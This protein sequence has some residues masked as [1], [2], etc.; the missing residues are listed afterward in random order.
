M[1]NRF[2]FQLTTSQGGRPFNLLSLFVD[3]C[4]STH[5]LARR[6]TEILHLMALI[7]HYFNSRPRKEVD[8]YPRKACTPHQEFQ[9]TTSQGGRLLVLT[10]HT[11]VLHF[12]SRPRK[13]VDG[14]WLVS[15][16]WLLHLFQLT[17]SQGGRPYGEGYTPDGMVISTH[18]LARRSTHR[19]D[20]NRRC[21]NNF[22]SRPR[23]EVDV[24][25]GI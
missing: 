1:L 6:S 21:N 5:D 23:K 3:S 9:L 10:H 14:M 7:V 25:G 13:E 19:L 2:L 12:N 15:L 22:N 17:T 4:I 20:K 16:I 11:E 18:D 24:W 8:V